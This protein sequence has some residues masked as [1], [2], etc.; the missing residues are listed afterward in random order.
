MQEQHRH[1]A[2]D[3]HD[4][5]HD[6]DHHEGRTRLRDRDRAR[7]PRTRRAH[8]TRIRG[9]GPALGAV[10]TGTAAAAAATVVAVTMGTAR[11]DG[12]TQAVEAG[13]G[14]RP[15]HPRAAADVPRSGV[16]RALGK[17]ATYADQVVALANSER[18]K[19]GCSALRV[20]SRLRAAA[21]GHAD[22][23]AARG[24]YRHDTPEGRDA[25]ERME[26]AGYSWRTWG[27]NIHR[28]PRSPAR[29][30]RDWMKSPEHRKNVLDCAFKDIGV[31]VNLSSNGPWWVQNFGVPD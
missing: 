26:A 5:D 15:A 28:G 3:D 23:M 6:H 12:D 11:P 17:A 27:E 10:L 16:D 9:G 14:G 7:R 18:R 29:T 1:R 25:G 2:N 20:N 13:V 21:Q 22:D 31:G 30:V 8:R 4:R 19:A 24:Y